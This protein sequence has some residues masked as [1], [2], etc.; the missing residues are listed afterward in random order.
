MS[1]GA[2][3]AVLVSVTDDITVALGGTDVKDA[4][5]TSKGSSRVLVD[6]G[7]AVLVDTSGVALAVG[8]DVKVSVESASSGVELEA[9]IN[10]TGL[11][12]GA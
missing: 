7:N 12:C 2:S 10:A 4:E 8:V 3:E 6:T 11:D 9:G 5:G 1:V